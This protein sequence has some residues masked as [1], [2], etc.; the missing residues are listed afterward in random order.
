[1]SW[2]VKPGADLGGVVPEILRLEPPL[3]A[4]Y[5][6]MGYPCVVTSG[7]EGHEGDGIHKVGS[8]HYLR[9]AI[10][11]RAHM[12]GA[13]MQQT[14]AALVTRRLTMLWPGLYVV[15]LEAMVTPNAHLHVQCSHALAA[16][17]DAGQGGP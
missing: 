7:C 10:D 1:M 16:M 8:Y 15:L 5:G 12:F 17:L 14:L 2:Q 13:K 9:M 6:E 11:L 3:V 4:C